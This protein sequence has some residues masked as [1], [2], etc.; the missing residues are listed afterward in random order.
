ASYRNLAERGGRHRASGRTRRSAW[1]GRAE[2]ASRQPS[3]RAP[4]R[5]VAGERRWAKGRTIE[6]T[7][8]PKRNLGGA[9]RSRSSRGSFERIGRRASG[10]ILARKRLDSKVFP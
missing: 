6:L 10:A 1:W 5:P 2:P 8:P 7:R 3:H 9:V 4:A